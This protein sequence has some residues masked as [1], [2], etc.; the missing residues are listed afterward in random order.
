MKLSDFDY[1]LPK[2]SI[3]QFP[4]K[5][6]DESRLLVLDRQKETLEH[7]VFKDI[8][9]FLKEGDLLVLN[10]TKVLPCRLFGRRLTGGR[11]E[12][13][14]LKRKEGLRF[15]ALMKPARL[16]VGEIINFNGGKVSGKIVNKNEINFQAK[17]VDEIYNI[18]LMP[19]PPYIKR[20]P[21]DSDKLDYQT[22]YARCPGAV[23]SPTAGLHFTEELI[24]QLKNRGINFS[25]LTLHVGLGTFKPVKCEDVVSYSMEPEYFS[26][27]EETQDAV[28]KARLDKKRIIAV[29]STSLRALESFASGNKQGKTGLYIYPGYEFKVTDCLVTNFHLPKTTL[30]MLVCAFAGEKLAKKAY[31]EAIDLKYRFYSYGDAMLIK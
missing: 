18:G 5:K 3:A 2:E 26:I 16:K 21:L 13:L 12:V 9:F 7:R 15:D 14:L 28:R 10:D 31:Q 17:D 1:Y 27:P 30:F 25:Y 20:E 29:G 4:L 6:R 24:G 19:L 22:V 8:V 23:A 11:V